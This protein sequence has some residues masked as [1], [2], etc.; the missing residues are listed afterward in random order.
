MQEQV[1]FTIDSGSTP[2]GIVSDSA[3]T[4]AWFVNGLGSLKWV[5]GPRDIPG[6]IK[7][8][9]PWFPAY[10]NISGRREVEVV[11]V[12]GPW[13]CVP[14][15]IWTSKRVRVILRV[16]TSQWKKPKGWKRE[17]KR[18][19]TRV[20]PTGWTETT[21]SLSHEKL[22]GV[23]S[24]VRR[25]WIATKEGSPTF[26]LVLPPAVPIS[27]GQVLSQTESGK[28]DSEPAKNQ[29]DSC[30]GRLVSPL[31]STITGYCV[32]NKDYVKRKLT[33]KEKA[34]V[35]DFPGTRLEIMTDNET[36]ILTNQPIPGKFLRGS[37]WF[38]QNDHPEEEE[39]QEMENEIHLASTTLVRED[40]EEEDVLWDAYLGEVSDK[41]VKADDAKVQVALWN[42]RVAEKFGGA[43]TVEERE[44]LGVALDAIR[45]G[46]LNYWKR[47][48]RRDFMSWFNLKKLDWEY[49]HHRDVLKS[50]LIAVSKAVGSSFWEW[51]LGSSLFF[52][53]FPD[54]YQETARIGNPPMFIS[55]PPQNSYKQPKIDLEA[56]AKVKEKIQTALSK[57]Y[58]SWASHHSIKCIMHF[59]QVPKGSE[60]IR[61]VYDGTKSGLNDALFAP[62]FALPTAD[63]M[64]RWVLPGCWLAD[65]DLGDCFLNFPLHPDLQKYCGIDLA[66]LFP[67][68][69]AEGK[70]QVFAM[71]ITNAMG[72]KNS[73]V[74]SVQGV[75]VAKYHILG[76]P[77]EETN[78]FSWF[79]VISNLPGSEEY[80]SSL[81]WVMKV[82]RDGS[83]ASSLA[84]YVDDFRVV[85]RDE[86]AAWK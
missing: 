31:T 44:R 20:I 12:Q 4:W 28:P 27:L 51:K 16:V 33:T 69:D 74:N 62:W 50:G 73:P 30:K 86:W 57:G 83:P 80:D 3:P 9:P 46:V 49:L 13:E 41:A 55:K 24:W 11:L 22:G 39:F 64:S 66:D 7:G 58:L 54:H 15:Q 19:R 26:N 70:R 79:A 67:E 36:D 72:L 52:W 40:N 59:F 17:R 35:M 77:K 8:D 60:D 34:L 81:P 53:R 5:V 82:R 6:R 18:K 1:Q 76:N 21:T 23:T 29:A 37:L 14:D 78:P 25:I 47:K 10:H 2:V 71:W 56:K 42:R 68:L 38:L 45:Q 75:T 85:A 84:G 63:S 32:F 43:P 65:N 48:V 61:M